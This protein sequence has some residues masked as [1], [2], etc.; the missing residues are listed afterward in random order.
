MSTRQKL[1]NTTINTLHVNRDITLDASDVYL[2][3]DVVFIS[4]RKSAEYFETSYHNFCSVYTDHLL[5]GGVARVLSGKYKYY[6]YTDMRTIWNTS[7]TK[8]LSV[9]EVCENNRK[10]RIKNKKRRK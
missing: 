5:R 9:F 2:V 4:S 8:G 10:R 3:G 7:R 1:I 6:S